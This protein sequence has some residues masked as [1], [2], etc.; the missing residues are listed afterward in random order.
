[1]SFT[2]YGLMAGIALAVLF[3]VAR[4]FCLKAVNA[5]QF[6]RFTVLA[7]SLALVGSR[8]VYVLSSIS[9][10][11]ETIG[12]PEMI[13]ALRDGGYSMMGAM[14]GVLLAAFIAEKWGHLPTFTLLDAVVPG[15]AM[16]LILAR[17]AEP[18][19]DMGWGYP[20]YSPLF[21]FL[22][23]W[24]ESMGDFAQTHPV[25]FYEALTALVILAVLLLLRRTEAGKLPGDS[26]LTFL[27]LYGA[28]QALWESMLNG[29]HMVVIHFVKINQIAALVMLLIPLAVWSVRLARMPHY[30]RCISAD[31]ALAVVCILSAVVQEF[32]VEGADNPYFSVVLVGGIMAGLLGLT[33]LLRSLAW[34]RSGFVA[35]LPVIIPAV[36]AIAAAVIDRA[37]DVGDHYRLVL[38]GIM[39]CDMA[40]LVAI[41]LR[42]RAIANENP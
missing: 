37:T 25:F 33:T 26:L 9:Y 7:V 1:M 21:F 18:F 20:Y 4:L 12:H 32:S 29:G 17:P 16:A 3:I 39:A 41:G 30:R 24:T 11:T 2:I 13:F 27:L 15:M 36:I 35:L 40:I 28:T 31:W 10:Y 38:W 23:S 8:L 5:G 14:A 42:Q 22:D 19:T 6:L 34:K